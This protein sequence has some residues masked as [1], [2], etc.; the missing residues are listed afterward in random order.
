MSQGWPTSICPNGMNHLSENALILKQILSTSFSRK[1][2]EISVENFY[3][4]I[5]A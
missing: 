3:A 4:D 2:M 1:R 5:G